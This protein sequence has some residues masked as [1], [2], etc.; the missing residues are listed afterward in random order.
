MSANWRW[1]VVSPLE[2]LEVAYR[3]VPHGLQEAFY[4]ALG[5]RTPRE[6]NARPLYSITIEVMA[7]LSR[8]ADDPPRY[9]KLVEDGGGDYGEFIDV[10]AWL[11]SQR[12]KKPDA[13]LR[14]P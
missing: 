3:D 2:Q 10:F 4:I 13:M 9:R 5:G 12:F 14:I 8:V 1:Q 11:I 6:L 7:A